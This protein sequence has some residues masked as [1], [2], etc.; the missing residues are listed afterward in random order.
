MARLVVNNKITSGRA[1]VPGK[2]LQISSFT[3]GTRPAVK[4]KAVSRIAKNHLCINPESVDKMDPADIP[5]LNEFLDHITALGVATDYDLIGLKPNQREIRSP[6]VT[7]LVTVVE[8]QVED[9][10]PPMLNKPCSDLR[11]LRAEHPSSRKDHLSSE[12]R[13]RH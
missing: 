13:I 7:H 10:A 6:P 12:H 1:L 2:I 9:T 4:T 5:S 8:E 11:A 3:I